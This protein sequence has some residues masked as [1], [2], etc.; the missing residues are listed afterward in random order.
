MTVSH[1]H[2]D[3]LERG[4]HRLV[5]S[6]V[7]GRSWGCRRRSVLPP[8]TI[9]ASFPATWLAAVSAHPEL[10]ALRADGRR[11]VLAVAAWVAQRADPATLVSRPLWEALSD[12]TGL[13]RPSV[14]R[15]LSWL[16]SRGLL[17]TVAHGR[18]AGMRPAVLAGMVTEAAAGNLAA[19]YLL[20]QPRPPRPLRPPKTKRPNETPSVPEQISET[21]SRNSPSERFQDACTQVRAQARAALRA[22]ATSFDQPTQDQPATAPA[23]PSWSMV[24][25]ARTR[26]EQLALVDRLRAEDA[27]LRDPRLSRR[28]LRHVL[29]PWLVAGWTGR[30]LEWAI[31]HRPEGGTYPYAFAHSDQLRNPAGFVVHRLRQWTEETGTIPTGPCSSTT[32]PTTSNGTLATGTATAPLASTEPTPRAALAT[33]VQVAES[34]LADPD[35]AAGYAASIR[36]A[37]GWDRRPV[38]ITVAYG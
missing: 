15:W 36:A 7:G 13:S 5:V 33:A 28:S 21:P 12:R 23:P 34:A 24:A 38:R 19:E 20:C 2:T 1:A 6:R 35:R 37:L 4:V 31:N 30:D 22:V 26:A 17:V 27:T 25:P 11:N 9:V 29:R 32:S 10:E 18:T 8:G 14:A 16:H 3:G